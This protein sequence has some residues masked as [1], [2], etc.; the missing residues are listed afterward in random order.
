MSGAFLSLKS[1]K[2]SFC[3]FT[4]LVFTIIYARKV[5]IFGLLETKK[6]VMFV[7]L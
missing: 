4:G 5:N 7:K 1:V 6:P 3:N 2:L